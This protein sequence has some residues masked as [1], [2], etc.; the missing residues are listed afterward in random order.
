MFLAFLC[1]R[2]TG[3][4]QYYLSS[5]GT[6]NKMEASSQRLESSEPRSCDQWSAS[7]S[8]NLP[9]LTRPQPGSC[10]SW[11]N[12]GAVFFR[13]LVHTA[14]YARSTVSNSL[15][16]C[17][18]ADCKT[19]CCATGSSE[20]S[21]MQDGGC[22]LSSMMSLILS[23]P[24]QPA[25]CGLRPSGSEARTW[26]FHPAVMHCLLPQDLDA[27]NLEICSAEQCGVVGLGGGLK[28]NCHSRL[29]SLTAPLKA[30]SK[31]HLIVSQPCLKIGFKYCTKVLDQKRFTSDRPLKTDGAGQFL[32]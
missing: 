32:A 18:R 22:S 5:F 21:L 26:D 6:D 15:A 13:A 28:T 2:I 19:T 14:E 24:V 29:P 31:P 23:H 10:S 25:C 20:R 1:M 27:V 11:N 12:Q 8:Q 4:L 30:L 17:L 9:M 7:S 3:H 16:P